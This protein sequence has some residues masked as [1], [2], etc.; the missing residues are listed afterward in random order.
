MPNVVKQTD[1]SKIEKQIKL[2]EAKPGDIFRYPSTSF[3]KALTAEKGSSFFMVVDV[4]PK[5]TGRV[6][7]VS[8]DGKIVQEKD[9]DHMVVVHPSKI[10]VDA[11]EMVP[12][13]LHAP[14]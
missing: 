9:S 4:I 2:E 10:V 13:D 6:T 14:Q 5:K 3:E 1:S 8:S 12:A 11:A 7:V